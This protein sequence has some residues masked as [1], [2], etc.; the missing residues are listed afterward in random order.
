MAQR[1]SAS[2][3]WPDNASL[4][5]P[6]AYKLHFEKLLHAA[7]VIKET[8]KCHRLLSGKLLEGRSKPEHLIFTF[9]CR[10]IERY[11]FSIEF[12][13]KTQ[14][15]ADPHEP[16]RLREAQARLIKEQ[17]LFQKELDRKQQEKA[18]CLVVM[19]RRMQEF[20]A[21][22]VIKDSLS[23]AIV[24]DD[25]IIYRLNFDSIS[26]KN[27]TLYYKVECKVM[28]DNTYQLRVSPRAKAWSAT[29]N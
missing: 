14:Q 11:S 15:I 17:Q 25:V 6:K 9:R 19:K 5:L 12:D 16:F 26:S 2:E 27:E 24:E 7:I 3:S 20:K 1:L 21:P 23:K 22:K 28:A 18:S 13:N 8:E 4:W 10:T 29:S